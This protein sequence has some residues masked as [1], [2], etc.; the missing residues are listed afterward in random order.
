[1]RGEV[2]GS[3]IACVKM[4]CRCAS[5]GTTLKR[6][7]P[8]R[9]LVPC[10]SAK[11]NVLFAWIGPPTVSAVLIAPELRLWS[12]LREQIAGVQCLIAKEL[13]QT[14]VEFVAARLADHHHRSAIRAAV[15]RRV[16]VD[17]QLELRHPVD[18][19]VIHHLARFGLQHADAVVEVFVRPRPASVDARQ[20]RSSRSAARRPARGSPSGTKLR[21]S[22]GSGAIFFSSMLRLTS[23]LAV[24]STGACAAVTIQCLGSLP[25]L[26]F[27]IEAARS[28]SRRVIPTL[29]INVPK[30]GCSTVM[31]YC[32]RRQSEKVIF[33]AIVRPCRV[34]DTRRLIF[35]LDASARDECVRRIRERTE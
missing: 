28:A 17:V 23:P 32:P 35:R 10:Q 14:A 5:V 33:P 27:H 31:R 12:R 30:P 25:D 9:S 2:A 26:Q 15:F 22:S 8:V 18:D 21:P 29:T 19:R 4:P 13:E 20:N 24:W 34:P 7:I 11:K 16:S 6:V 3:K 1:M